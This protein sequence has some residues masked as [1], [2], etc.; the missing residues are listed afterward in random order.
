MTYSHSRKISEIESV[1][2]L[3]SIRTTIKSG[4]NG[5]PNTA[6][7]VVGTTPELAKI[8]NL[9]LREGQFM[10]EGSNASTVVLGEQLAINLFGTEH[11]IGKVLQLHGKNFTVIGVLK[12]LIS[13]STSRTLTLTTR[14]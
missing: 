14:Q 5:N 6:Y 9:T 8:N 2:P 3:A 4:S 13:Q 7:S 10:D 12:R 11:A 1:A